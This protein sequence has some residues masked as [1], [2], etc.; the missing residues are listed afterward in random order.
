MR[1]GQL[2]NRFPQSSFTTKSFLVTEF[3]FDFI[4]RAFLYPQQRRQWQ[5][6]M[7]K[8]PSRNDVVWVRKNIGHRGVVITSEEEVATFIASGK[9]TED[10]FV[11]RFVH[12]PHLIEGYKWDIGVYVLVTSLTP[13]RLYY[14][15]DLLLRFCKE[16]WQGLDASKVDTYVI[17]DDYTSPWDMPPF[18]KY[19]Q[20]PNQHV[21]PWLQSYF[22]ATAPQ[23]DWKSHLTQHATNAVRKVI[24]HDLEYMTKDMDMW[25]DGQAHFFELFRFD[26]VFD[27]KLNPFLMEVNM[28]PNLSPSAHPPLSDMFSRILRDIG[29]MMALDKGK[30]RRT[31]KRDEKFEL[32]NKGS[33]IPIY[34]E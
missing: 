9:A 5:R 13:L 27:D 14:Y 2:V 32:E 30:E 23:A 6:Y 28:S 21:K 22:D 7:R 11:Q 33:W 1:T 20:S 29:K 16:P 8:L 26:F 4:P 25:P 31:M 24:T 10:I 18:Q 19:K 34:D 12:P 3:P 17:A 15:D